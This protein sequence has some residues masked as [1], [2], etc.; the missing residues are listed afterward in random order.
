MEGCLWFHAITRGTC[1]LAQTRSSPIRLQ[2][3]DFVMFTRGE[4]HRLQSAPHVATP[5]VL[6]LPQKL[7]GDRA[8]QLRYGGDGDAVRLLCGIARLDRLA[9]RA[10]LAHLPSVIRVARDDPAY[11]AL[12]AA[13]DLIAAESD[14][15]EFGS[16]LVTTRLADIVLVCA[17]RSLIK[18]QP[19][20]A[21][22]WIQSASDPRIGRAL[23]QVHARPT[24]SWTLPELAQ[25]AAMS[26]AA[27]AARF[28]KCVGETPA[29]YVAHVKMRVASDRLLDGYTA[30]QAAAELGYDSPAAFSRAFKRLTGKR[31]STVRRAARQSAN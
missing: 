26:R 14:A 7:I 18:T 22:A 11:A 8:S 29:Q 21:T 1:L 28:V 13:L 12:N 4:E 20:K 24:H 25:A 17:L 6:D 19:E 9:S 2:A 31:A 3:G 15:R 16:H 10:L 23:A 27:F 30:A 5:N